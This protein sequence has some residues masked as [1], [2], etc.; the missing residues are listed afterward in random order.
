MQAGG[1]GRN[2]LPIMTDDRLD[3]G[4]DSKTRMRLCTLHAKHPGHTP[5]HSSSHLAKAAAPA[6]SFAAIGSSGTQQHA[7]ARRLVMDGNGGS[8]AAG[9]ERCSHCAADQAQDCSE[10]GR[11]W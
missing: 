2:A 1:S 11:C 6:S 5:P 10:V 4:L 7:G 9:L 3:D 8:D